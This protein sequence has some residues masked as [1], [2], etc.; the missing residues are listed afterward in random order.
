MLTLSR[1]IHLR[2]ILRLAVM[3]RPPS[4]GDDLYVFILLLC[5]L[6]CFP[7]NESIIEIGVVQDYL[8]SEEANMR[9]YGPYF[10]CVFMF[11]LLR[12]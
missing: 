6:F 8:L 2:R 9:A 7:C 12:F 10:S 11:V 4:C 3:T 1:F 5:V